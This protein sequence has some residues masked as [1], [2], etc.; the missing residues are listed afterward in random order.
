[1]EEAC[2][3]WRHWSYKYELRLA[4]Q[5]DNAASSAEM[6]ESETATTDQAVL[7]AKSAERGFDALLQLN[8]RLSARLPKQPAVKLEASSEDH[9]PN[10][11]HRHNASFEKWEALR[12][13]YAK[14]PG[15]SDL[16]D[17]PDRVV[18]LGQW[19]HIE[20]GHNPL[21]CESKGCAQLRTG[22]ILGLTTRLNVEWTDKR[23][24]LGSAAQKDK[25]R[26]ILSSRTCRM[27]WVPCSL[28]RN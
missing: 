20:A 15:C 14:R 25:R 21:G 19:P 8:R 28:G 3:A 23:R 24:V 10:A 4:S 26:N 2:S 13:D 27:R 6:C 5:W 11:V 7:Q 9:E 1:M 17:E 18:L 22:K 16:W 12:C